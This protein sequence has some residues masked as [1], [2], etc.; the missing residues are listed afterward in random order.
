M[1]S[2]FVL[3][4]EAPGLL[5]SFFNVLQKNFRRSTLLTNM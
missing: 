5:R 2:S 4:G 1:N 3:A